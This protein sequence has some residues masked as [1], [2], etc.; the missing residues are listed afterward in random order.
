MLGC[1]GMLTPEEWVPAL[2][3]SGRQCAARVDTHPILGTDGVPRI[4]LT[5]YPAA[6]LQEVG[7]MPNL[8]LHL[9]AYLRPA[10]CASTTSQLGEHPD[11]R[12]AADSAPVVSTQALDRPAGLE[13][14]RLMTEFP[15]TRVAAV[16]EP[17]RCLVAVRRSLR[18]ED[19]QH[20][21]QFALTPSLPDMAGPL[22]L[23][24]S[25]VYGWARWWLEENG[26]LQD[27]QCLWD[28]LP[29]PPEE[30]VLVHAW[31]EH[32]LHVSEVERTHWPAPPDWGMA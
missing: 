18:Y 29:Q 27:R 4:H 2:Y 3:P 19:A 6:A 9:A 16:F 20:G 30:L 5:S 32:V 14:D 25:G 13:L 8:R 21:F 17:S 26:R 1:M 10:P 15:E 31:Q 7:C 12:L 28:E 22:S 24:A 11:G 23:Y